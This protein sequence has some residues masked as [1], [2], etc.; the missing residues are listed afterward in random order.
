MPSKHQIPQD[1][2]LE[3]KNYK[4]FFAECLLVNLGLITAD[5]RWAKASWNKSDPTHLHQTCTQKK[6]KLRS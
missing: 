2:I 6:K 1:W 5:Q 3:S 4:G